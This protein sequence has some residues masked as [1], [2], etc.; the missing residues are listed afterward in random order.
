M[1]I[2]FAFL[3][4]RIDPNGEGNQALFH[5]YEEN[6]NEEGKLVNLKSIEEINNLIPCHPISSSY[7]LCK[8]LDQLSRR[9]T[10]FLRFGRKR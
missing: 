5:T 8:K 4:Y 1:I 7:I 2:Y 3:A 10:G 9:D 6:G